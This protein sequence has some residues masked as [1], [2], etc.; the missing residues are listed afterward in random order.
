MIKVFFAFNVRDDTESK[1]PSIVFLSI[2]L[3]IT[4]I[5]INRD[6]VH[7]QECRL[8]HDIHVVSYSFIMFKNRFKLTPSSSSSVIASLRTEYSRNCVEFAHAPRLKAGSICTSKIGLL[9]SIG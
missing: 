3:L 8:S 6:W 7:N 5:A 9:K 4:I 1:Y 2:L